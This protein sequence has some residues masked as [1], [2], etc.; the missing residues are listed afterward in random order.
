[1]RDARSR[2]RE[3][4]GNS[5]HVARTVADLL[6]VQASR[7]LGNE[8]PTK[9]EHSERTIKLLPDVRE[10][11]RTLV[12]YRNDARDA[13][14]F[15]NAKNGGRINHGEWPKGCWKKAI[16]ETGVVKPL[17]KLFA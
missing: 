9:T 6:E 11:L 15:V 14:V 13:Y 8:A 3:D 16:D 12:Q 2:P 1:M 5:S 7:Y 10:I 4:H 17:V